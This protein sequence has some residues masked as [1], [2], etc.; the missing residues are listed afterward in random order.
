MLARRKIELALKS[1]E[2]HD[3][4]KRDKNEQVRGKHLQQ[5]KLEAREA[6]LSFW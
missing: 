2:K 3:Y 6:T 5:A 4:T 1:G